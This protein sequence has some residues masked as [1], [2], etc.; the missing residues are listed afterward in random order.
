MTKTLVRWLAMAW[1]VVM[2]VCAPAVAGQPQVPTVQL[3][4]A[5]AIHMPHDVDCNTPSHWDG[6]KF[7][8]FNSTGHPY[9]SSG[10]DLFHLGAAEAV[11]FDNTVNGGRWIE[12]T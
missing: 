2:L 7:Y 9:R 11:K 8:V 6:G 3:H 4:A 5:P 1:A 12:A 10:T